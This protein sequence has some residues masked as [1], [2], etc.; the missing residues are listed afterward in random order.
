MYLD[1]SH[2]IFEFEWVLHFG[3][4]V[5]SEK[6]ASMRI[7]SAQDG[8][9]RG[10]EDFVRRHTTSADNTDVKIVREMVWYSLEHGGRWSEA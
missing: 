2:H 7:N 8:I 5:Q 3:Q 1:V 4:N 6:T 10:V 9:V